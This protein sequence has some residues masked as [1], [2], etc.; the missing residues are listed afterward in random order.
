MI[1]GINNK[2]KKHH[3]RLTKRGRTV[4]FIVYGSLVLL[5]AIA[6]GYFTR[7]ICYVGEGG[8]FLGYGSCQEMIDSVVNK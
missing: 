8:N 5:L 6:F 2:L 7:D 4:V 1:D 3:L